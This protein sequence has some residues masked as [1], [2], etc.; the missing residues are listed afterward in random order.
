MGASRFRRSLARLA[1]RNKG[2]TPFRERPTHR[3]GFTGKDGETDSQGGGAKKKC[4]RQD[5]NGNE[6]LCDLGVALVV[7]ARAPENTGVRTGNARASRNRFAPRF[8]G[9]ARNLLHALPRRSR[10]KPGPACASPAPA[11]YRLGRLGPLYSPGKLCYLRSTR[12]PRVTPR[13]PAKGR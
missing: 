9:P 3:Q 10:A 12:V 8:R 11:L 13:G 6:F 4:N 5:A 7:N 1:E 2:N